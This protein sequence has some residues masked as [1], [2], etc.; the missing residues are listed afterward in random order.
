MSFLAFVLIVSSAVLHASWNLMAKRGRMS[1]PFYTLICSTCMLV[2]AHV[3][4]WTPIDVLA[5]P[6]PF[7][8]YLGG[9]IASD[10]V[11]C[12]G[13]MM[14]YR[15]LEMSTAYPV[16]RALPILLT[17]AVTAVFGLG[18]PLSPT[19]KLGMV[20]VCA[21]CLLMPLAK[22]A[23]FR[24]A[25]YFN[26]DMLF[27]LVT[28]CGTTGYTVFD[29]QAQRIMT[30]AM[31]DYAK[32]LRAITYYSVRV[33][34]L[35]SSLWLVVML[36]PSNRAQM[37]EF[38]AARNWTPCL[39]GIFASATYVLV[40]LSM[41]YVTN[42]SYVQV[43]RQLGLPIGMLAGVF[44]LKERCTPT[45]IIGVALILLGLLLTCIQDLLSS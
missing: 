34:L 19:A 33:V 39:A 11:Y 40:L 23:E 42:V 20:V 12:Y 9:S 8:A 38:F 10:L 13:L 24:P 41:N 35:S 1:V 4:F 15:V 44:V 29:S 31:A 3:L 27:V 26:S 6:A 21:G 14:A 22:F 37:R 43:F 18:T 16:M 36:S 45:K 25:K 17:V 30:A 28:A 5:L 7:W 32:P 2:W